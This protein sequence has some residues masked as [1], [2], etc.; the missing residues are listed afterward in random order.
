MHLDRL[1]ELRAGE[2]PHERDRLGGLILAL[3]VDLGEALGVAPSVG[4]HDATSTPIERAV[5]GDDLRR[6]LDVVRVQVRELALGDLAQ[7]RLGDRADLH[8]VGLARALGD[9]EAPG[10]SAPRPGGVFVMNVNER[11]S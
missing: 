11:S 2:A 3:A 8:A 4:A 9:V 1:V 6:L 5:P 7:L 10:G